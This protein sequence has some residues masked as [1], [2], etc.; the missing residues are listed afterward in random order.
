[1]SL[2]MEVSA[3]SGALCLWVF[4]CLLP[5]LPLLPACL[6]KLVQPEGTFLPSQSSTALPS[7]RPGSLVTF[8]ASSSAHYWPLPSSPPFL[9]CFSASPQSCRSPE[10]PGRIMAMDPFRILGFAWP[11]QPS[12]TLRI[13][14]QRQKDLQ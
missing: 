2:M 11:E 12:E 9:G 7:V 8:D 1:M 10:L 4:H 14:F 6:K 3:P 13:L 5:L